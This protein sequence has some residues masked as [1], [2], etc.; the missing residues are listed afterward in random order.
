MQRPEPLP[1]RL[2]AGQGKRC[3]AQAAASSRLMAAM[4]E[5][6]SSSVVSKEHIQRTSRAASFQS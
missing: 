1:G 5:S 3:R 2:A 6:T 4:K